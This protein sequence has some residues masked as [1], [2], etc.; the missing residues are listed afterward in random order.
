MCKRI[1]RIAKGITSG[2]RMCKGI[3]RIGKGI[4]R[5]AGYVMEL[6]GLTKILQEMLG[7]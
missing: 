7:R 6:Q 4:T 3:A 1:A 5:D 2:C